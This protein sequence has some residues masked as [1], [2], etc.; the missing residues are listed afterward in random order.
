MTEPNELIESIEGEAAVLGSMILDNACIATVAEQLEPVAFYRPENRELY[1]A[2]CH[3]SKITDQ[4][5]DM[6]MLRDELKKRKKLKGIGG[7][8]Y[9]I[10]VVESVPTAANVEYYTKMVGDAYTTRLLLEY[11][12]DVW[13]IA[14]EHK[15]VEE[16]L[17]ETDAGLR[18][19]TEGQGRIEVVDVAKDIGD[20]CDFKN[21][22]VYVSTG[23]PEL[24][25]VMFGLG[26]GDMIVV[27]GRSSMGKTALAVSTAMH[28]AREKI[29]V[30]FF[31]LEMSARQL[32]Q[33][34]IIAETRNMQITLKAARQGYLTPHN[35][36]EL[37]EAAMR[38]SQWIMLIDPTSGL[39]MEL[40]EARTY[41]ILMENDI[42][43]I[44]IDYL[45]LM[46]HNRK[47]RYEGMT[48]ISVAVKNLARKTDLPVVLIS[49]LSRAPDKRDDK[50]PRMSDLRDS[51]AIEEAADV[52]LL[53]YRPD[54]YTHKDTGEAEVIIAKQRNGETGTVQLTFVKEWAAFVS[55]PPKEKSLYE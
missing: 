47:N 30:L 9:I 4:R 51:G 19:L 3:L 11:S 32:E 1:M 22:T 31:S 17:T 26:K 46:K 48:D 29:G 5:I 21:D 39:T 28:L 55:P 20:V 12:R 14:S 43:V 27:A 13:R 37:A 18:R 41:R 33:R 15:T 35:E 38:I 45:Q 36:G 23:F 52:I 2:I 53:L 49:Q 10:E 8:N 6:V 44:M 34:M 50:R 54:Y 16:K 42:G 7:V 24:D 25:D 40:L